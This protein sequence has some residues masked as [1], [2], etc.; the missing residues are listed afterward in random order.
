MKILSPLRNRDF[1]LLYAGL[2]ISLLGDGIYLVAIAWQA[3]DISNAPSAF[4]LVGLAWSLSSVIFLLAGGVAADRFERRRV[5]IA[6]DLVR[7]AALALMGILSV[8][9]SL[10]IWH[11]V[12][13][14]F[15]YAAGDAFFGPAF[16]ALVPD[17]LRS[18]EMV[19]SSALEQFMRQSC[20][21]L[22]GPVI[23]G[24]IIA[25]AGSGEA[26]LVDAA[27][28]LVSAVTIV[29]VR[30]RTHG[31]PEHV[32]SARDDVIAGL[33]YAR[34]RRWLWATFIISSLVTLTFFGPVEVLL[35]YLIRNELDGTAADFGLVLAAD[36]AGSVLASILIAQRG[37]PQ[38]S[39]ALLYA[40]WGA[41]TLPLIGYAVATSLLQLMVLGAAFGA[42][43]TTGVIVFTTLLQ[44]RVP[45][46]M[47]GRMHSLDLFTSSSLG[48]LSFALTAPMAAAFGAETTLIIAG[49][50]MPVAA[51]L[52]YFVLKIGSQDA[53][54]V[55]DEV[56]PAAGEQ[57]ANEVEPE[58]AGSPA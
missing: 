10:E 6:A 56:P 42:L 48:P 7:A 40:S 36:G 19:Q 15:V 50:I 5:M 1:A 52:L 55:S 13:I 49:S 11:M 24:A 21:R 44:T 41:C 53:P 28:F 4:A 16:T 43:I 38:R 32:A 30:A 31:V 26:L 25:A 54:L 39:M 45:A 23:G 27:T 29:F 58:P 51:L 57:P 12:A 22:I 37:L 34:D 8:T 46:E 2:T 14:V 3:Y 35:P 17:I 33:R 9:G 47:R 20:R 18:D